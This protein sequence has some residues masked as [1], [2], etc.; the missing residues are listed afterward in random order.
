MNDT[1]GVYGTDVQF[2]KA[3]LDAL[4]T[5]PLKIDTKYYT[6]KLELFHASPEQEQPSFTTQADLIHRKYVDLLGQRV[7]AII[8]HNGEAEKAEDATRLKNFLEHAIEALDP[9][10]LLYVVDRE[11]AV[12]H[13]TLEWCNEN[14]F[15]IVGLENAENDED[16]ESGLREK[17]GLPRIKE[18]LECHMWTNMEYKTELRPQKEK[19]AEPNK[20]EEDD[21]SDVPPEVMATFGDVLKFMKGEETR[22]EMAMEGNSEL[23][24]LVSALGPLQQ[25][26]T[27]LSTLEDDKRRKMAAQVAMALMEAMG[28]DD[29]DLEDMF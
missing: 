21:F 23:E 7:D 6:A 13:T 26:R 11:E 24:G 3:K 5:S 20:E 10:V 22:S 8:V 29:D 16:E 4:A 1:I 19:Q 25:L 27:Q 17:L 12:P 18:A 15:E 9:A 2:T 28:D 14:G